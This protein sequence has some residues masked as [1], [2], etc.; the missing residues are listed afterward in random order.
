MSMLD[1]KPTVYF[2]FLTISGS[3]YQLEQG[4]FGPATLCKMGN[5]ADGP[6]DRRACVAVVDQMVYPMPGERWVGCYDGRQTIS[7]SPVVRELP[8]PEEVTS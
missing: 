8:V 7:T 4:P 5:A 3:V 6:L 1:T 2:R